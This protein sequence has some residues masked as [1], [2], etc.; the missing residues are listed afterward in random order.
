MVCIC[1]VCIEY[2]IIIMYTKRRSFSIATTTT[3]QQLLLARNQQQTNKIK[4]SQFF[5]IAFFFEIENR[6]YPCPSMFHSRQKLFSNFMRG[7][8]CEC[9][10]VCVRVPHYVY[11]CS[12][13]FS[14]MFIVA[15][16]P[17][18]SL[19]IHTLSY[20]FNSTETHFSTF[21]YPH[22]RISYN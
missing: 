14:T 22:T 9:E 3:K 17:T 10:C 16:N 20:S 11:F 6:T 7:R 19:V 1:C 15:H 2:I 13:T 21:L 4:K 8:M 5:R 18:H 12:C